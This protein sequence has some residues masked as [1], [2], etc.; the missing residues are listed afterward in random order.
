M[1]R[2]LVAAG[3]RL[4]TGLLRQAL[5]AFG[6]LLLAAATASGAVSRVGSAV[7]TVSSSA[8]SVQNTTPPAGVASG[9]LMIAVVG[10][11]GTGYPVVNSAPAGWTLVLNRD[12]GGT[13]GVSI[14]RKLATASEPASYAWGLRNNDRAAGAIVAFRGVDTTTPVE[15]SGTQANAAST[16]YTAPSIT[17]TTADTLLLAIFSAITGSASFTAPTDMVAEVTA[18]GGAGPNGIAFGL[19]H[20]TRLATG[21]TGTRVSTP[22]TSLKNL[23]VLLALRAAPVPPATVDHYELSLPVASL[24]CLPTTV[25]VTACADNSSPCTST[26]TTV[27]GSTAAL[28]TSGAT[29]GAG[30]L[31]FNAS[32]VAS[33]TLSYPSAAQGAAVAVTL[34]GESTAA[35]NPRRCCADGTNCSAAS[36]CTTTFN[37]AGLVIAAA[38]NGVATTLPT[39]TAGTASSTYHLRAVKTNTATKA[40]EA[41]LTG[42]STVNWAVQC[43]NPSSC[44]AGNLMTVSGG[45]P[46]PVAGNPASAV[47]ATTA[48]AMSFDANGNAPFSISHADVGQVM[49]HAS[50]VVNGATLSGASN[51]FVTRPAGLQISDVKQTASPVL[52]NPAAASAAGS[53]FVRAGEGFTV[54][55]TALTSTGAAAPNFGR[56]IVPEGVLLSAA[57]VLP[58][59]G[60]N[61]SLSNATVAGAL[62]A[63]GTATVTDLAYSEVGIVTLTPSLADGDYLGA[64]A[65]IGTTSGNIGR[66]VPSQFALTPGGATPACSNAFSYFGQ[67]GFSTSH[68]LTAQNSA[69]ATTQNYT[70]TWAKLGLSTWVNHGFAAAGL[71]AG[72]VLSTGAVPPGGSWSAGTALVS[73]TH[74]VSRPNAPT[75]QTSVTVT[76]APTDSDGVGLAVATT[77]APATPLRYGR[78]RLSNAFGSAG[79]ALQMPVVAEQWSGNA[80]VLNSADSCTTLPASSVALSNP[81]TSSG[82]VSTATTTA[83]S[84]TLASGS[85][86]LTLAAP[87]PAGSSLSLDIALNLGGT[88]ADQSC[89]ASRPLTVG[90]ARSW[91]RAQNGSCATTTDRDPAARASF[92]I[93]SPETRRTVH[94]RELF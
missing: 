7:G 85:G 69:G 41:A 34:S 43:Q 52:A 63:G 68:T 32:G 11:R 73:A 5:V 4:E 37:T 3:R 92:G 82:S 70:G 30:T 84:I 19:F 26:A 18:V 79:T 90:A 17:T 47:T 10:Q 22:N 2:F 48:V 1:V 15:A 54:T 80:W 77:V 60:V 35:G 38:A 94:V 65:V 46:T 67:D 89:L 33:T 20:S 21:A 6:G 16:S 29:L 83:G 81:R 75:A 56:E 55:V 53:R 59:G 12:D 14:Y 61:G 9:D 40:C 45:T 44:S 51:A 23:G 88:P 49:L 78:L 64:G 72:A 87:T 36:S 8:V 66:F 39:Q 58:A 50:K 25:T 42:A 71:P 76:S 62:F 31:T 91:L 27:S 74:Q 57:L 24:N 28:S 86:L 13:S 93:F